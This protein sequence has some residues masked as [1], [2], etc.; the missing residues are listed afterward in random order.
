[1]P[2][3]LDR[4]THQT[5]T[6]YD[7]KYIN[8]EEVSAMPV[9]YAMED[10]CRGS[11]EGMNLVNTSTNDQGDYCLSERKSW[12]KKDVRTVL[13]LSLNHFSPALSGICVLLPL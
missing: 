13:S 1:M 4:Q 9:G 2:K 11:Q 3:V 8:V 5:M 10:T 7:P 12:C 6:L